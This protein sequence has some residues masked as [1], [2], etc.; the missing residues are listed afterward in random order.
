[1]EGERKKDTLHEKDMVCS[2][3]LMPTRLLRYVNPLIVNNI[4]VSAYLCFTQI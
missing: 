2:T 3:L 1:M 4:I